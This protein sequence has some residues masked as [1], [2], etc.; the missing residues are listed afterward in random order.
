MCV[1]VHT[2]PQWCGSCHEHHPT[3]WLGRC[4]FGTSYIPRTS[5]VHVV[6]MP[7]RTPP[8]HTTAPT[9]AYPGHYPR[10]W[11]L[12]RSLLMTGLAADH[13][14]AATSCPTR[15]GL[16]LLRSCWAL[17]GHRR[18]V[19][20]AGST[21]ECIPREEEPVAQGPCPFGPSLS[22]RF[23]WSVLTTVQ[24]HVRIPTPSD[25]AHRHPQSG[26]ASAC[27]APLASPIPPGVR[28]RHEG[29]AVSHAP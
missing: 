28:R 17:V 27:L 6:C 4:P 20:S 23:G 2:A 21:S 3:D 24:E 14:L 13:L 11:L 29:G 15:A 16:R 18:A 8:L 22:A 19:L 9:S 1:S 26:S 5:R 10:P 12:G 25:L 7:T